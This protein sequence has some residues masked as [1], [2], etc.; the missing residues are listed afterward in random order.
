MTSAGTGKSG[1]ANLLR[2]R[3]DILHKVISG[4]SWSLVGGVFALVFGLISVVL[5]ARGLGVEAYGEL[6]MLQSTIGM[7]AILAT[8]GL[9]LTL[10]KHI[11]QYENSDSEKARKIY[12][13][14]SLF[15]LC[16][17]L[18]LC[19]LTILLAQYLAADVLEASHLVL[20][21][22]VFSPVLILD[23]WQGV[24]LGTLSGFQLFRT[25]AFIEMLRATCQCTV[26][27]LGAYQWGLMGAVAG[28]LLTR[29]IVGFI[30][31]WAVYRAFTERSIAYSFTGF[32]EQAAVLRSFSLPAALSGL[33]VAPVMWICNTLVVRESGGF[34]A[35]GI[36]NAANQIVTAITVLGESLAKPLLPMLSASSGR[37]DFMRLLN[38]LMPWAIGSLAV[39]PLLVF[40]GIV[41]NVLGEGYSGEI[42]EQTLAVV[43]IVVCLQLYMRG[44]GREVVARNL[45]WFNFWSNA[46]WAV[47][48][49]LLASFLA[50][51]GSVGL[52]LSYLIGYAVNLLVFIPFYRKSGLVPAGALISVWPLLVWLCLIFT[53]ILSMNSDTVVEKLLLLAVAVGILVLSFWKMTGI[54]QQTADARS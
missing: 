45:V 14:T 38:I 53:G 4:G 2:D 15:S 32:W 20:P 7:L 24:Q 51:Y 8:F 49:L 1:I 33:A 25:I 54:D 37:G 42:F 34:A 13:L 50:K 10:T 43:L 9:G 52:A 28:L 18:L 26:V 46:F 40:P 29:L 12:A 23:A 5:V 27:V 47:V 31:T 3:R 16:T 30:T 17:G 36:Y 48:V 22:I 41:G 21:L 11:A 19:G 35:L 6:G 44:V 39:V